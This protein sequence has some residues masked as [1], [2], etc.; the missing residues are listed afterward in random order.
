MFLSKEQ[1]VLKLKYKMIKSLMI[2]VCIYGAQTVIYRLRVFSTFFSW[3]ARCTSILCSTRF[4]LRLAAVKPTLLGC[5]LV[6][7]D[8]HIELFC[9]VRLDGQWLLDAD[10]PPLGWAWPSTLQPCRDSLVFGGWFAVRVSGVSGVMV[11]GCW[12]LV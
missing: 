6:I 4:R 8:I 11:W 2:G 1:H 7:R 10:R 12:V 5:N 9:V 3:I